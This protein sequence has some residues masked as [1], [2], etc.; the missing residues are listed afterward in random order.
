M[1]SENRVTAVSFFMREWGQS[2]RS[3]ICLFAHI[4]RAQCFF[5]I[6]QERGCIMMKLFF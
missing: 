2:H 1:K 5:R 4:A 6:I 3:V